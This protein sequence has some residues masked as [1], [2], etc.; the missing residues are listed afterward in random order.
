MQSFRGLFEPLYTLDDLR[1]RPQ[2]IHTLSCLGDKDGKHFDFRYEEKGSNRYKAHVYLDDKLIASGKK[3]NS[4]DDAKM[5]AAMEAVRT[6]SESMPVEI[7]MDRQDIENED[8]KDKLIEICN[9]RKWPNPVYRYT[10]I[11]V[12]LCFRQTFKSKLILSLRRTHLLIRYI[13]I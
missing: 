1:L 5:S 10:Y 2:P 7:V 8:A 3:K 9:K 13:T 12:L 11:L 4:R 6:L